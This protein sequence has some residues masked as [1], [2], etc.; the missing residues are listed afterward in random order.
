MCTAPLSGQW[1]IRWCRMC[2]NHRCYN[3]PFIIPEK[4]DHRRGSPHRVDSESLGQQMP[5]PSARMQAGHS[6]TPPSQEDEQ[7]RERPLVQEE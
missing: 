3:H 7:H 1:G 2:P 4:H 6:Q 5:G